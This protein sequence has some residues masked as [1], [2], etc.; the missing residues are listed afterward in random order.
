MLWAR[1]HGYSD[2]IT[3]RGEVH[4]LRLRSYDGNFYVITSRFLMAEP[5]WSH[6][7]NSRYIPADERAAS[8]LQGEFGLLELGQE[9]LGRPAREGRIRRHGRT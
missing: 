9:F 2:E 3:Y 5:G 7:F 4:A 6:I 1:S 8:L